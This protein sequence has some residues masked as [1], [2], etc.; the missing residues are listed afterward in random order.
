MPGLRAVLEREEMADLVIPD[1]AR[2]EDW[3]VI[4]RLTSL[5]TDAKKESNWVASR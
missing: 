1:L 2:W 4:E 5:F 3:S